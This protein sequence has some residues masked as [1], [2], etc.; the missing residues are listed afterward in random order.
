MEIYARCLITRDKKK[1]I[2]FLGLCVYIL[3]NQRKTFGKSLSDIKLEGDVTISRLH[4]VVSV[5]PA[6]ESEVQ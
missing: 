1:I 5:E 3:P 4:A 6:E 2:P